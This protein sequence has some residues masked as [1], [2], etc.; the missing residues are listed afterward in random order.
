MKT[1][2]FLTILFVIQTYCVQAFH[3]DTNIINNKIFIIGIQRFDSLIALNITKTEMWMVTE[4]KNLEYFND[5]KCSKIPFLI[6]DTI[7]YEVIIWPSFIWDY[8]L[9]SVSSE[10]RA[11]LIKSYPYYYVS[12][13][14]KL[15]EE[16][17][18]TYYY[19]KIKYEKL[20]C[21]R[22]L[23]LLVNIPFYNEFQSQFADPVYYFLNHPAEQGMYIKVLIPLLEN[24]NEE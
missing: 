4:K 18:K 5:I 1:K 10:L 11:A 6:F 3:K 16:G 20:S 8:L 14:V 22:F 17:R 9:N 7:G 23:A 12:P 2:F 19:K 21:R 13:A 24:E 15:Y